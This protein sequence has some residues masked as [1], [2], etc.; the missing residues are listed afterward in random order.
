M[1]HRERKEEHP[2]SEMGTNIGNNTK[3]LWLLQN[4]TTTRDSQHF[5]PHKTHSADT[6]TGLT[7]ERNTRTPSGG[8]SH[9]LSQSLKKQGYLVGD[10]TQESLSTSTPWDEQS[11]DEL[12]EIEYV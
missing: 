2:K 10:E 1:D 4:P 9:L 6:Q 3:N 8:S 11:E 12:G 7:S 5:H